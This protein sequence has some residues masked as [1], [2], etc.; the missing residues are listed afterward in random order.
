MMERY[1]G[2][3]ISGT[4]LPGPPNTFYWKSLGIILKDGRKRSVVEVGR[5]QHTGITFDL[6]GL[7][8]FYE[9]E[10]GSGLVSCYSP[11]SLLWVAHG[12]IRRPVP[13]IQIVPVVPS[14]S[15]VQGLKCNG[16]KTVPSVPDVPNV[17]SHH[18]EWGALSVS[19]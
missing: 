1:K 14:L 16:T 12:L 2:Y 15:A 4:A 8:E 9:S 13:V 11:L 18:P 19:P 10:L 3:W 17:Q 6:A 5:I 7:A